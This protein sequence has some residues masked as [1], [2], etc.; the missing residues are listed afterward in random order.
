M[1]QDWERVHHKESKVGTSKE[2]LVREK[3]NMKNCE[4]TYQ[5]IAKQLEKYCD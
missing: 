1:L 4:I 5:N 2:S 3:T